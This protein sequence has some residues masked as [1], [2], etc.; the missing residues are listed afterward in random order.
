M[1]FF[2]QSITASAGTILVLTLSHLPAHAQVPFQRIV[3]D[4]LH[5]LSNYGGSVGVSGNQV[6]ISNRRD[7]DVGDVSGVIDVFEVRG[8]RW[9]RVQR[10]SP[11]K[12]KR[13][14]FAYFAVSGDHLAVRHSDV[15]HMYASVDGRWEPNGTLDHP[16]TAQPYVKAMDDRTLVVMESTERARIYLRRDNDWVDTGTIPYGYNTCIAGDVLAVSRW[17][18][19]PPISF[20]RQSSSGWQ[21][22]DSLGGAPIYRI[23]CQDDSIA[24][25][26]ADSIRFTRWAGSGLETTQVVAHDGE[27]LME[28]LFNGNE[29]YVSHERARDVDGARVMRSHIDVLSKRFGEWEFVRSVPQFRA[30]HS[31]REYNDGCLGAAMAASDEYLVAAAP[32][33]TLQHGDEFVYEAGE[34]YI[35]AVGYLDNRSERLVDEPRFDLTWTRVYPS[36][37]RGA[38]Q[39]EYSLPTETSVVAEVFDLLGRP[40]ATIIN[41]RQPRGEHTATLDTSA[42]ARGL[43]FLRIRLNERTTGTQSFVVQ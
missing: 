31:E 35:I 40:I 12:P 43:Y 24:I 34:V 7:P 4:S 2:Q 8:D 28:L 33:R 6:L 41:R 36:P 26:D 15:I 17:S 1:R 13:D 20:Y 27:G 37:G 22:A 19:S 5:R 21:V 25:A 18:A 14:D 38:T 29:L 3:P 9:E 11:P 16:A 23:A 32:V 10:L 39:F 30:Q 42:W